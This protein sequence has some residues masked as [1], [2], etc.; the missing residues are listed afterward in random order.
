[1]TAPWL[2]PVTRNPIKYRIHQGV[3]MAFQN[4]A[5]L[6]ASLKHRWKVIFATK[7]PEVTIADVTS[8]E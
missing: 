6:A 5:P 1:M 2:P 4:G 8:G 7:A 3:L